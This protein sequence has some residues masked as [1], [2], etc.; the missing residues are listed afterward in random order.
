MGMVHT[1]VVKSFMEW[2]RVPPGVDWN[3]SEVRTKCC[4]SGAG[5][6]A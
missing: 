1:S 2:L 5:G 4:R 6:G 3:P